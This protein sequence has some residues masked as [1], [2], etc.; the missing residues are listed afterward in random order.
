MDGME[1]STYSKQAMLCRI[2]IYINFHKKE[3]LLAYQ[4]K[5]VNIKYIGEA[6]CLQVLVKTLTM[7]DF[8]IIRAPILTGSYTNT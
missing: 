3:A 1:A 5:L 4:G 8:K 2:F 7:H 6:F